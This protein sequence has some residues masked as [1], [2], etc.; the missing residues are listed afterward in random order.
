MQMLI[1][2]LAPFYALC[3]LAF[4]IFSLYSRILEVG[5]AGLLLLILSARFMFQ[6]RALRKKIPNNI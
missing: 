1:L 4:L 3:G 5:L 2:R 6:L